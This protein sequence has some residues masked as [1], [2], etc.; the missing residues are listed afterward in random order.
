[1]V[2]SPDQAEDIVQYLR[3]VPP[4]STVVLDTVCPEA[5]PPADAGSDAG[6]DANDDGPSEAGADGGDAASE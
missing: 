5:G 3:T 4:V 6:P 1:M 2:L